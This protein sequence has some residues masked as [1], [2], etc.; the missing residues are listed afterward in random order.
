MKAS[1]GT[2]ALGQGP[3]E[4]PSRWPT[5]T[6]RGPVRPR[7]RRAGG[8]RPARWRG[9][10]SARWSATTA[11][12][13]PAGAEVDGQHVR[14]PG[15]PAGL[16]PA[17]PGRH[18]L[19]TQIVAVAD[20]L[21]VVELDGV[22]PAPAAGRGPGRRPCGP[23]PRG[24][25]GSKSGREVVEADQVEMDPVGHLEPGGLAQVLDVADHLAGQAPAA[26]VVVEGQVEGDHLGAVPGHGEAGLGP[27]PAARPRRPPARPG[28]PPAR[29]PPAGR[30]RD[31]PPRR[32]RRPSPWP[33]AAAGPAC[34]R[35]GPSSL[36]LGTSS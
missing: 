24:R 17:T 15:R 27:A 3:I 5:T 34:P 1:E 31:R 6:R 36:K 10:R 13:G 20:R 25:C 7:P 23:A 14:S 8:G 33:P 4:R 2:P 18:A 19:I 35:R 9:P 30:R 29:P 12:F 22:R 32:R 16:R 26:Q 21:A 11:T 28:R